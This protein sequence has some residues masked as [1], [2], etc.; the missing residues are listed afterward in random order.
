MGRKVINSIECKRCHNKFDVA[1]EDIEWEH[2]EDRGECDEDNSLHDYGIWQNAICHH[3]NEKNK[4]L[5]K[6]RGKSKTDL[7]EIE[8]I[9]MF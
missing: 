1:T 4:I 5:V 8:V 6:A 9:S 3:C 2:L 7:D